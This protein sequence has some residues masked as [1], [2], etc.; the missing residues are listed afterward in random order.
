MK[1]KIQAF[2]RNYHE[3]KKNEEAKRLAERM[4]ELKEKNKMKPKY[5]IKELNEVVELAKKLGMTKVVELNEFLAKNKMP[6]E[7]PLNCLKREYTKATINP[8]FKTI[9]TNLGM[10]KGE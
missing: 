4:K 3:R 5:V 6:N 1:N 10:I 2:E 9:F 8:I 7:T